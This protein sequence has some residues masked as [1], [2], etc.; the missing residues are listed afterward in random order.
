VD[1]GQINAFLSSIFKPSAPAAKPGD[2]GPPPASGKMIDP[3]QLN[4]RIHDGKL[5]LADTVALSFYGVS[6]SVIVQATGTFVKDGSEF[7]FDP[8]TIY[9]GG[10]PV[11]RLLVAKNWILSKMLLSQPVP[12]DISAAWSKLS[13][14]AIEGTKL[15]LKAP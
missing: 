13:D 9:V 10:C 4:A 12:A 8:E 15:R 5:Q 1:E 11:Q 3:G 14:V 6:T 7:E 2:K